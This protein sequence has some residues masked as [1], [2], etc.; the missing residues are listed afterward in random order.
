[1]RFK[2]NLKIILFFLQLECS[3]HVLAWFVLIKNV[4]CRRRNFHGFCPNQRKFMLRKILYSPIR[5]SLCTRKKLK[6]SPAKVY[7]RIKIKKNLQIVFSFV[8]IT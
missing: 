6:C 1:M 4:Y 2:G 3:Q 5:E 7:E 8:K